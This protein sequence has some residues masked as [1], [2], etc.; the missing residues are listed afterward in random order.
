MTIKGKIILILLLIILPAA[1]FGQNI[2]E[3]EKKR[4]R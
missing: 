3:Q 1:V 4:E 2:E